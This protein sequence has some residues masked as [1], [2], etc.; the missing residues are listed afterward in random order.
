MHALA[1]QDVFVA[2]GTDSIEHEEL[3]HAPSDAGSISATQ[4]EADTVA[5]RD[6]TDRTSSIFLSRSSFP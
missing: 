6:A 1:C 5:D 3:P 2:D 4:H